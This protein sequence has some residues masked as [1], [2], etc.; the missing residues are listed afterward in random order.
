MGRSFASA[1]IRGEATGLAGCFNADVAARAKKDLGVGERLEGEDGYTVY[2]MIQPAEKSVKEG[3]LPLG[4]ASNMKLIRPV[5]KGSF[6]TWAD[7]NYDKTTLAYKTR[8]ET[9][10]M[11]FS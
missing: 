6:V 9:E 1:A 10:A 4:L 3:F 2:G 8:R 5:A 7:V 11:F